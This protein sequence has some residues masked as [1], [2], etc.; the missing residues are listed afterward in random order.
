LAIAG[1]I[2]KKLKMATRYFLIFSALEL[3]SLHAPERSIVVEVIE[4]HCAVLSACGMER[5]NEGHSR[6]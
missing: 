1:V 3:L 2:D 6:S 4:I 5:E